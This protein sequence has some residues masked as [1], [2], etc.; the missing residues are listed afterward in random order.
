MKL[1]KFVII[2]T[3]IVMLFSLISS[4]SYAEYDADGNFDTSKPISK[5]PQENGQMTIRNNEGKE[6]DTKIT[7]TSTSGSFDLKTI[8]KVLTILPV[9]VNDLM[10][11]FINNVTNGDKDSFTIYDMVLGHYNLFNIDFTE[12]APKQIGEDEDMIVL[13]RYRVTKYYNI[14]RSLSI[15]GS[16]FVLIYIGIRMA[17]STVA[18]QKAR[19]KKMLINWI[20]ALILLFTIQFLV[21]LI[22]YSLQIGLG[23]VEKVSVIFGDMH[24]FE[25]GI[26]GEGL[27]NLNTVGFNVFT[28]TVLVYMITWYQAKFFI[29]YLRRALEVNFLIII[30][31]LV[32]LTYP[33]DKIGDGKAQAFNTLFKE[34]IMKSMIQ[35]VHAIVYVVFIS[36]AGYVAQSQ[37]FLAIL[38]FGALSRAE[39]IV[40]NIVGVDEK[41][42][43]KA[44]VP[45][46]S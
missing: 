45:F 1:K 43:E 35:L 13:I 22:S 38:F 46:T 5:E 25:E 16:L 23:I 3:I 36:T 8:S 11:A 7:G 40:R 4:P 12:E 27:K 31:P 21:I 26:Y 20:V 18:A 9:A 24:G 37:P 42:F 28:A 19:Y 29:Y 10:G 41:G 17:I 14:T 34:I 32:A 15:A 44:N 33:I 30:S 2:I 39:K 6:I